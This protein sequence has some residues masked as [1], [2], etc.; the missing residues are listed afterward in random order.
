M[1]CRIPFGLAAL[2]MSRFVR[3]VL[4]TP[5]AVLLVDG[6]FEGLSQGPTHRYRGKRRHVSTASP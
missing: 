3:I 4:G 6:G 5:E 2:L 1:F